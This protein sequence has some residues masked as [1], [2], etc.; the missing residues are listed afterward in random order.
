MRASPHSQPTA[1]PL[2]NAAPHTPPT[3]LEQLGASAEA[4]PPPQTPLAGNLNAQGLA[5]LGVVVQL[6]GRYS[7]ERLAASAGS[8]RVGMAGWII[9]R[10]LG[11]GTDMDADTIKLE[12]AELC[13]R[14]LVRLNGE[15]RLEATAAG[16]R[17]WQESKPDGL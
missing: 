1:L 3:P 12:V 17:L 5:L 14:G 7:P 6:S 8:E 16:T 9:D 2:D 10:L 15:H 11:A 4:S 13:E